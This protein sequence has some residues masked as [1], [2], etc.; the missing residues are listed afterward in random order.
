MLK[1]GFCY[2]RFSAN[3]ND[4]NI[5]ICDQSWSEIWDDFVKQKAPD[6]GFLQ[7]WQWGEFQKAVGRPVVRLAITDDQ[8]IIRAVIQLIKYDLPFD[9]CYLYAPRGPV[10]IVS[11]D[12]PELRLLIMEVK[13]IARKN[14]AVFVKMD[15]PWLESEGTRNI[16]KNLGF[17]FAGEVQPKS[18]L[19]LDLTQEDTKILASMK[20]KTR[21]NIKVAQKHCIQIDE[22]DSYFEDFW[23]LMQKTAKRDKIK[24]H[25]KKHYQKMIK[26]LGKAGILRLI[27]AKFEDKVVAAN[28]MIIFGK[29]C[30]YLHGA[31]DHEYRD[32]MAPYLLQWEGITMAKFRWCEHYDFFGANESKWPG[33]T[34]FKMGF[35]PQTELTNYIGAWN[36]S[37]DPIS[38]LYYRIIKKILRRK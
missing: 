22:G 24:V 10:G 21:Y 20:S 1:S 28:I 38:Y 5:I 34:R 2:A 4:M 11:A 3:I 23:K 7:S 33:V 36:M 37:V 6:G 17:D 27:V 15:P 25:S 18:T 19:I 14:R 35:A 9:R 32:K 8:G 26:V 31:S 29:W 30:I 13:R 12:A 16:L